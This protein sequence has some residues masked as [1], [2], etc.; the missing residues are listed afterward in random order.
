MSFKS[1]RA[2]SPTPTPLPGL[3]GEPSLDA[4]SLPK[5]VSVLCRGEISYLM[6]QAE[7]FSVATARLRHDK[8]V[9]ERQSSR[10]KAAAWRRACERRD[11]EEML[12]RKAAQL[13]EEERQQ[14]LALQ[15]DRDKDKWCKVLERISERKK[16]MTIGVSD[17][18]DETAL[19]E[20]EKY[21]EGVNAGLPG[22]ITLDHKIDMMRKAQKVKKRLERRLRQLADWKHEF[23]LFSEK[24]RHN[25]EATFKLFDKN[26]NRVVSSQEL[27]DGL[28][29]FGLRGLDMEERKTE[30]K[31]C[32]QVAATNL[33]M[34]DGADAGCEIY[35][36]AMHVVPNVRRQ[37]MKLR[38]ESM[39]Q[40]FSMKD[41]DGSG[42]IPADECL[43][44]V[45]TMTRID[46]D[47]TMMHDATDELKR[48]AG[49]LT[50]RGNVVMAGPFAQA[51][52]ADNV[53]GPSYD[54]R[55]FELLVARMTELSQRNAAGEQRR[56][57]NKRNLDEATFSDFRSE[58]IPLNKV[59]DRVDFDASGELD[60][61]ETLLLFKELGMIPNSPIDKM[62][63]SKIVERH[64]EVDFKQFLHL[65]H[66]VRNVIELRHEEQLKKIFLKHKDV[67]DHSIIHTA[68]VSR[69]LE[70]IGM[71]TK[72]RRE[73]DIVV[74]IIH[75]SDREDTGR[76]SFKQVK[77][78]WQRVKEQLHQ[79][80][81]FAEEEV[82]QKCKFSTEEIGEFRFAFEQLDADGSGS[83]DTGE[84]KQAMVILNKTFVHEGQFENAMKQMDSDGSGSLE[85]TEFLSL[86]QMLRDEEG[87]F[88]V[89]QTPLTTLA[90]LNRKGIFML[91]E[92]FKQG[93]ETLED[94]GDE[95][96]VARVC[97]L[98][99]IEDKTCQIR[100][101]IEVAD[102][103]ELLDF[104]GRLHMERGG[105]PQ[106]MMRALAELT[107]AHNSVMEQ[108]KAAAAE[109]EAA[110]EGA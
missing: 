103:S 29:E 109:A 78:I 105:M 40:M 39:M 30:Y 50:G 81:L 79:L 69:V 87:V 25:F 17:D 58:L 88:S 77:R 20:S 15:R 90:K 32:E 73:Q 27:R 53:D 33:K 36:F 97:I 104:A 86:L 106:D 9:K 22:P 102:F 38:Q 51:S 85:F 57:Q 16:R 99:E 107:E 24:D 55:Q 63:I 60:P 47:K 44:A 6:Q 101:Y 84:V 72:T 18:D 37:F 23:Q 12:R 82:A 42:R 7:D 41:A 89:E 31:V 75:E 76:Y 67:D 5:V 93:R 14:E 62:Q 26:G 21:A 100:E 34:S 10:R 1:G 54:F 2:G 96:L 70:D 74:R 56:I 61:R 68:G 35:E 13:A 49:V 59:F 28:W 83:L 71:E 64:K 94:Y 92:R 65:V 4:V 98:L 8:D 91:L 19:Q 52:S 110:H 11:R 95:E 3:L 46:I 43:D 66:D 45:R 108:Q 48:N 80:K